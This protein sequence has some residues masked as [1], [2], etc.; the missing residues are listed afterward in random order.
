MRMNTDEIKD[1]SRA[2]QPQINADT[3]FLI[4]P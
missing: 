3:F 4:P 2:K 1:K